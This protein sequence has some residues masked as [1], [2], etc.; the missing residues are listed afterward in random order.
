LIIFQKKKNKIYY[1]KPLLSKIPKINDNIEIED[2][3]NDCII[4]EDDDIKIDLDADKKYY[5]KLF[6]I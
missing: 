5:K 6:F 4:I 3:D 2:D 1:I